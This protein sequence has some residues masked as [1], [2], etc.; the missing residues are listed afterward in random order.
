MRLCSVVCL[1]SVMVFVLCC[2]V[3]L[4]CCCIVV[5]CLSVCLIRSVACCDPH[6][7]HIHT[8][9]THTPQSSNRQSRIDKPPNC[10]PSELRHPVHSVRPSISLL[11]LLVRLPPRR[12]RAP[13]HSLL[14]FR[15]CSLH[16]PLCVRVCA[17]WGFVLC[18]PFS[19]ATLLRTT[20]R[21]HPH[22]RTRTP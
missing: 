13:R 14:S 1:C 7:R 11:L 6:A 15:L 21:T 8:T 19:C 22:T 12:S 10:G 4:L 9:H 20:A 2:A 16:C 17:G 18:T 5:H 3:V